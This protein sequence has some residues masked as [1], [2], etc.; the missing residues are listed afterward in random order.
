MW[1]SL[2]RR[3]I[4]TPSRY[5]LRTFLSEAYQLKEAWNCRLSTPILQ[6]INTNNFYYDLDQRFNQKKK[7]SAIDV[8]IF[9]NKVNDIELIDEITDLLYKLRQTEETSNVLDSTGH[10]LIRVMVENDLIEPLIQILD[11]RLGYGIFLDDFSCNLILDNLLK[12]NKHLEAARIATIQML[13]E[14]F[15][16]PITRALSL[17][18]CIKYVYDSEGLQEFNDLKPKVEEPTEA[19]Q[20]QQTTPKKKKK[21]EEIKVRVKFLR[22]PYFDDHFDIRNSQH[23]VGK[24]LWYIGKE[25]P[26]SIGSSIRLLGLSLYQKYD[27]ALQVLDET[28]SNELYKPVTDKIAELLSNVEE[29]Q[30]SEEYQSF[31]S[32]IEST[33][34]THKIIDANL[35]TLATELCEKIVSENEAKEIEQQKKIYSAWL[36]IR[37]KKLDEE[38]ERLNRVERLKNIEKLAEDMKAEEQR[39]W[40]FEN[41]DQLD[42]QIEGKRVYYRKRWFGKKKTPRVIDENYVPPEFQKKFNS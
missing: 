4:Q 8:D 17:L 41:E 25:L 11:N 9:V 30:K 38:I 34:S 18:A 33:G 39:L 22:N 29:D 27:Q 16:N 40:F 19:Q 24:T 7:V 2:S 35:E 5:S 21:P 32:A 3:C 12:S 6:K 36:E 10:A 28:K 37:K 31:K 20:Q 42:L 23:L 14:D 13:Q 1:A 15:T 26:A